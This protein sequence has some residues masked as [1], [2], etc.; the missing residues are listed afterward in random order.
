MAAEILYVIEGRDEVKIKVEDANVA[1]MIQRWYLGGS[2]AVSPSTVQS[3]AEKFGTGQF[4]FCLA[5]SC[6]CG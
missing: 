2:A 6:S 5:F 3:L 1:E 4:I